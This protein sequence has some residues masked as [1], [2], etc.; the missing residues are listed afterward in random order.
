MKYATLLWMMLLG[1]GSVLHAAPTPPPDLTATGII[2]TIKRDSTYNL[3]PTG[4]RGWFHIGGGGGTTHGEDGTMTEEARQILVTVVGEGT[5]ATGVLAVDDVIL[6]VGW[7]KGR[8]PLSSFTSDAR[9]S[10]GAAISEAEKTA[11]S[12][13]LRLKR[14]RAGVTTDVAITLAVLGSYSDTAPYQCPKSALILANVRKRLVSELLAQPNFL[15]ADFAGAVNGLALLASASPD[16]PDYAAV[17]ARLQT[18]ARGAVTKS[19]QIQENTWHLA[20]VGLFLTEYYLSTGDDAILPGLSAYLKTLVEAGSMYGTF[21]HHP[22]LVRPDGSGRR[23]V[24]GYGPINSVGLT[25]NIAILLGKKALVAGNQTID[26]EIDRAIQRGSDFFAAYVNRGSIPYG[27]HLPG[28]DSHASNGKDAMCAV[29]FGLQDERVAETEYFTRLTIASYV[30]RET[31]HANGPGFSFLWNA[32]GACM[33]G[34]LAA[35]EHLR[36]VRWHLDLERRTDGS[37]VFDGKEQYGGGATKD[38]TY[39]GWSSYGGMNSTAC[40]LLTYSLPLK[41][42]YITGKDL[43]S[44]HTLSAAKMANA[45]AAATFKKGC[46]ALTT[47]QLIAALKEYDPVV[48][49]F[50]AVELSKR[51]LTPAEIDTLIALLSG[52]DANGRM[53][54]CETLGR[55]KNPT[56]MPLLTQRLDKNVEP[57]PWVRSAAAVALRKY[58]NAAV[59]HRDPMLAAF[60]A[61]A[62]DPDVIVWKDPL[63]ASNTQLSYQLFGGADGGIPA[64]EIIKAPKDLLYPAAR[65]GLRQPDSHPRAGV[66]AFTRD[67]LSLADVQA[68]PAEFINLVQNDVQADRMWSGQCRVVGLETLKKYKFAEGIPIAASLLKVAPGWES[69]SELYTIPAMN[70]LASNGDA[71]RWTLPILRGNLPEWGKQNK[72][73][74]Y[75]TL[76]ATIAS[77]EA[78]TTSPEGLTALNAVAH[79]Q[80]LVTTAPKAITL[81][82]SSCRESSVSFTKVSA[83]AHGKLTGTAPNLVYT[84]TPGYEGPDFFTFQ[85][86]DA[87]TTS[88]PAT[89]SLIVG[90]AGNGL[91][92]EYY[93]GADIS[94][95]KLTRTDAQIAFD[96]GTGSPD[97]LI[98]ADAFGVRWSGQLLVPETG[99]YTFSTL[100]SDGARLFI[101]G[102]AVIDAFENHDTRWTDGSPIQLTAGQRVELQME[103]YGNR[104]SAVAKLKWTGPSFA[105]ANGVLIAQEW[106]HDGTGAK[107]TPYA[108]AQNVALVKN[109]PQP[110]TLTGSG[111][112]QRYAIL[113]PPAHGTLTG[114]PPYLTYTPAPNYSGEDSF[115]FA[116]KNSTATSAPATVTISPEKP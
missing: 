116:V 96:W 70:L 25:A 28:A 12:G 39:L 5:P 101:N 13:I 56:A 46:T 34:D 93:D 110:I 91:K 22:A 17:Q 66:V 94:K 41:R 21:G 104:G 10:F 16:D 105:G 49:K 35:V 112:A 7:G 64:N 59:T 82:G 9:K 63:Q 103:Y 98:G 18:F 38:G 58:G 11:N 8:G 54:A 14:W 42:L 111:G 69:W 44:A 1:S 113:A 50:A 109:N 52:A 30:A 73:A 81:T 51:P 102:V 80:L 84:P 99:N 19:A 92:G 47:S 48:R 88:E 85:A 3:G 79:P 23:S 89:I 33:G 20:Y 87:L 67:K 68:M 45:V 97:P 55:L 53:S 78:A 37:F 77:L 57:D 36:R 71:A 27:E 31:G 6:G 100:T 62:S 43:K 108:H 32:M 24:R 65:A 61:N 72:K 86:K 83:P 60:A 74:Q 2:P 76:L 90:T 75:E 15:S 26:P 115:T 40:F 29:L 114:T 106:L 95:L 107:R 4:M